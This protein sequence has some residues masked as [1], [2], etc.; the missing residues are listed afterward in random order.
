MIHSGHFTFYLVC[1]IM[2][3]RFIFDLLRILTLFMHKHNYF[4]SIFVNSLEFF[5]QRTTEKYTER[6]REKT[7]DFSR[8]HKQ[9]N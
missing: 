9:M 8:L 1:Q 2:H 7:D 4:N 3:D 6:C 5:T